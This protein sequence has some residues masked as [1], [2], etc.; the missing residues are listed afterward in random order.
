MVK[1]KA[2]KV[3]ES[4]DKLEKWCI[5]NNF[6]AYDP[7]DGLSS[8]LR[9]FSLNKR[10]PQIFLQQFVR[11]FPIFNL[12]PILGIYPNQSAKGMGL[13]LSG[14]VSLFKSTQKKVYKKKIY[15]LLAWLIKHQNNNYHGSCWGNHFDYQSK[16]F[17]LPKGEPTVVWTSLI[18]LAIIRAFDSLEDLRLLNICKSICEFIDK[19]LKLLNDE[20]GSCISYIPKEVKP[21][22]NANLLAASMLAAT[23]YRTNNSRYMEKARNA[24]YYTI[25]K[26]NSDYSWYYGIYDYQNWIDNWHTGY[27]LDSLKIYFE[28]TN[29][30]IVKDLM[31][32]GLNYYI[33]NF[34]TESGLAK[35]YHNQ[36]YP[37]DI[38]CCSQS[39]KT[40]VFFS[41]LNSRCLNVALKVA[42]WTIDNMQDSEGF[43]YF[44]DYNNQLNK[45]PMMHWGQATMFESLS[46]LL[47][48]IKKNEAIS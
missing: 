38:Q 31:L 46:M 24:V 45:T 4:V 34:F 16:L 25:K 18:G 48:V 28:C 6:A 5:S 3:I 43:F 15:E 17:Y 10:Y 9:H 32:K 8:P 14:Y 1:L 33:D 13:I 11:R 41:E 47:E 27:N 23:G 37:I 21:V 42:D 30:Q 35:Y 29:D 44:R 20:D 40:L 12:R 26:Q 19:D 39:I 2:S 36:I 7:F 22:H